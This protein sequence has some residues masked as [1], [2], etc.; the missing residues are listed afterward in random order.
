MQSFLRTR[1][2][3]FFLY[4]DCKES[5]VEQDPDNRSITDI[6]TEL[7][8]ALERYEASQAVK[9][10]TKSE[11]ESKVAFESEPETEVAAE[12]K[13]EPAVVNEPEPEI[14]KSFLETSTDLPAEFTMK[15]V[16]SSPAAVRVPLPLRSPDVYDSLHTLLE[17][18]SSRSSEFL[19]YRVQ[20]VQS[21]AGKICLGMLHVRSTI[22]RSQL[23]TEVSFISTTL[24]QP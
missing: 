19:W 8:E 6:C 7:R 16:P 15:L 5:N 4:V 3:P 9:I 1:H 24:V 12:P 14:E 23:V 11:L 20:S 17:A 21:S 13:S 2:A 10:G 18:I 22:D